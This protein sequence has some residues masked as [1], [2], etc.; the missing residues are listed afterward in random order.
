MPEAYSLEDLGHSLQI[1]IRNR[2]HQP[3]IMWFVALTVV[4]TIALIWIFPVALSTG[5]LEL[6]LALIPLIAGLVFCGLTL[7]WQ[8]DGKEVLIVD[9]HKLESRRSSLGLKVQRTFNLKSIKTVKAMPTEHSEAAWSFLQPA[10]IFRDDIGRIVIE[11]GKRIYRVGS[12]LYQEEAEEIVETI[13]R[14]HPEI[15]SR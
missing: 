10:A 2:R 6:S 9:P 14:R 7:A 5:D 4:F 8:F 15:G 13:R 1:T 12:G 11:Q 3:T